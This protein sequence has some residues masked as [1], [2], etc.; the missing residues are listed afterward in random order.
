[1]FGDVYSSSDTNA[2]M[3]GLRCYVGYGYIGYNCTCAGNR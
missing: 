3:A 2:G 1:M